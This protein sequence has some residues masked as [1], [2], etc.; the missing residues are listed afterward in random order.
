MSFS[1][2]FLFEQSHNRAHLLQVLTFHGFPPETMN[3]PAAAY[4]VTAAYYHW[5]VAVPLVGCVGTVLKAQDAPKSE[6]GKWMWRHKSLGLLTGMIVAPRIGYRLMNR[7]AVSIECILK[8][9]D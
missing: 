8:E 6:K 5:L 1:F 9:R 4:S 2:L 3:A 7:K